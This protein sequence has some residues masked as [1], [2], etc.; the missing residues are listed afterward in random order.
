MKLDMVAWE[1]EKVLVKLSKLFTSGMKLTFVVRD[2]KNDDAVLIKTDD[3]LAD[4]ARVIAIYAK[5]DK[6]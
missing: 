6:P 1:I 5:R 3:D 4:L 2:P